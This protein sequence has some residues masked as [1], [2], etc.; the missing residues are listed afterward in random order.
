MLCRTSGGQN[1]WFMLCREWWGTL[2]ATSTPRTWSPRCGAPT[3]FARREKRSGILQ[4]TLCPFRTIFDIRLRYQPIKSG[5][6]ANLAWPFLKAISDSLFL[7]GYL[8]LYTAILPI[9]RLFNIWYQAAQSIWWKR[10]FCGIWQLC[11]LAI[12]V[13]RHS[14]IRSLLNSYRN[15]FTDFY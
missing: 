14:I 7:S 5:I 11:F 13:V 4:R 12:S 9:I 2:R 15:K 3:S 1:H 8:L 10:K 6:R